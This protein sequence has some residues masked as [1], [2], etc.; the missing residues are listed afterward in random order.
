M[1]DQADGG[2]GSGAKLPFRLVVWLSEMYGV[3]CNGGSRAEAGQPGCAEA[4][5]IRHLLYT[6]FVPAKRK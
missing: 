6:Q 3:W 1:I 4:T 2:C 5:F